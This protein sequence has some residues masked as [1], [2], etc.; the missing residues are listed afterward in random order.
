MS[1]CCAG[2]AMLKRIPSRAGWGVLL[3]RVFARTGWGYLLAVVLIVLLP[4][5][6]TINSMIY[7]ANLHG[8]PAF[9][10]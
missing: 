4:V 9:A 7:A 2:V 5:S 3:R 8:L 10:P 6:L 1:W